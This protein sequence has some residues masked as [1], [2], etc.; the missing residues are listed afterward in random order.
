MCAKKYV[1]E[2]SICIGC[3]ILVLSLSIFLFNQGYA[4]GP[5][6]PVVALLPMVP[7]AALCWVILRQFRRLD[8]MQIRIQLEGLAFAFALTAVI[9]FSY[10]FLE[11]A[12]FPALSMFTVWP[13]M[14]TLW[15]FGMLWAKQRYK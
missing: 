14:G 10:G 5:W 4:V 15:S 2:L 1:V 13:L 3:Y 6:R 9:T 11:I 12:G 8:E 7:G